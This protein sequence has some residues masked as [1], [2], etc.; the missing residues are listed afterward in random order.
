MKILSSSSRKCAWDAEEERQAKKR[1]RVR[2][3]WCA[4]AAACV[5][6]RAPLSRGAARGFRYCLWNVSVTKGYL[7]YSP[8]PSED[9]EIGHLHLGARQSPW[10][11]TRSWEP[12]KIWVGIRGVWALRLFISIGPVSPFQDISNCFCQSFPLCRFPTR[13]MAYLASLFINYC[14]IYGLD[15]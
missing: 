14:H 3:P 15:S 8:F 1:T 9:D 12:G 7:N 10:Q 11:C 2:L 4:G 6:T 5:T 13:V